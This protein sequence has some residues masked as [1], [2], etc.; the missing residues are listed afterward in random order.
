MQVEIQLVGL[1]KLKQAMSIAPAVVNLEMNAGID[2]GLSVLERTAKKLSPVDT[3][4]L[5]A[6]HTTKRDLLQMR[7]TLFPTVDYAFFVHEGTKPHFPPLGV[8]GVGNWAKKR[9]I[10]AFV[11]GR[12][13]SRR[14]TD[15]QPWL[16]A[17]VNTE[18]NKVESIMQSAVNKAIKRIFR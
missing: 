11:V 8:R 13:I 14:G 5:R 16:T 3:G 10:P 17:T 7:G 9:N 4:R 12:A 18:K 2:K 6:S 1:N 15:N